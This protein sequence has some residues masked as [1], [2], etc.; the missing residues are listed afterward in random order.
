MSTAFKPSASNKGGRE[1][2]PLPFAGFTSS[3]KRRIDTLLENKKMSADLL[4]MTTYMAAITTAKATRPE[5]FAYTAVRTEYV[6]AKYIAKVEFFVKRWN[7]SYVSALGILAER[8]KNEMLRS[9]LNRYA[10]SI[11]SGVPDEDFLVR[12]LNTIRTVYRNAYEQ[13]L[14]MLK[15]W[16][17][18]YIAMLFS[19]SLVGIIIMVSIAIFSPENV[20]STLMMSYFIVVTVAVFGIITMY[21]SVPSDEKTH[22]LP[23]GSKEQGMITRME[24]KIIPI[25]ISLAILF[26]VISSLQFIPDVYGLVMLFAGILLLPLGIIGYLDDHNIV[27]RDSDFCVF[28]RSLGAVMGGKGSSIGHALAEIDRKSLVQ[29]E[30][31]INSVYSKLN[32]GLDEAQSWERFISE[33][34]SNLIYKYLNIYRDAVELGGAPDKIGE[35]VGSSML[36]QVLLREKRNTIAMGFVVL[37]IPMHAMMIAIFLFLFRILVTMSDAITNVMNSL[38]D[39]GAGLSDSGSVGG[40]MAGSVNMFTNF[41]KGEMT[42]YVVIMLTIITIANVIAGKIVMGGNRYMFYF[43]AAILSSI[44]AII[45]I[46]TPYIVN[47][48]F[49][50]PVYTGV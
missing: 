8:V 34:G 13:G 4:F 10:N 47:M 39:M 31:L 25:V 28:I 3:M 9:M 6:P 48:F 15:K 16:G 41:P 18:A 19:S 37:L 44:T 22:T 12:E 7:Y 26:F 14:E 23:K 43:F 38:G 33:S 24:K 50:I 29:L 35:I 11:E 46:A 40:T 1:R 27:L 49:N 20:Q 30:P 21:R 42:Q 2:G 5:I 17:D 45:Y 32:L 36:E